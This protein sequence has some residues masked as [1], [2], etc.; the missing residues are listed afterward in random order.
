MRPGW[1]P[2][3]RSRNIGTARQGHGENKQMVIPESWHRCQRFWEN[4]S[5]CVAVQR[6]IG[7]KI[8]T[9]LVE[10]PQA[11]WFYPCS[12]DDMAK[13]L[14]HFSARDLHSFDFIVLRQPTRKQRML[15]PVWGRAVS[16]V[17]I[18]KFF[19]SA[20]VIEA[21]TPEL[22]VWSQSRSLSPDQYLELERLQQDGHQLTR[23]RRDILISSSAEAIRNTVLYRTLPHEVGHHVDRRRAGWDGWNSKPSSEKEAYA[24]RYAKDF[25]AS[26]VPKKV[27]PFV[28]CLDDLTLSRD[29]LHREWFVAS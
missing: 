10:P 7:A 28:A 11:A 6:E 24:H 20:I 27:L 4:L 12:I 25:L 19:G 5:A 23:R 3:R 21:Q 18:G 13:L 29:G 1:N 14:T 8:Q 9:F 16:V 17:R 26:L 2:V 22:R 15:A